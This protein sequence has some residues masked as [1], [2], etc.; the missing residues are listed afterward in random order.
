MMLK[1]GFFDLQVA[2]DH[3]A[4]RRSE[5]EASKLLDKSVEVERPVHI[6]CGFCGFALAFGKFKR[7]IQRVF[8]KITGG[9][10]V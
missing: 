2:K 5:L 3:A 8:V 9:R 6:P 1:A 10:Y 7:F 4:R